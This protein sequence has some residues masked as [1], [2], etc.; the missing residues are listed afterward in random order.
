[1]DKSF[2]IAIILKKISVS[3]YNGLVITKKY[4][5]KYKIFETKT[6]KYLLQNSNFNIKVGDIVKIKQIARVSKKKSW[7]ICSIY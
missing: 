4:N 3:T 1:M 6:K 2:K 5:K 7:E